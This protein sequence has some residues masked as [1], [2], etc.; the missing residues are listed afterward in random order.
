MIFFSSEERTHVVIKVA[1]MVIFVLALHL[2][3]ESE[4]IKACDTKSIQMI[5]KRFN[6]SLRCVLDTA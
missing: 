6:V 5:N 3:L 4:Q 2:Y 1:T